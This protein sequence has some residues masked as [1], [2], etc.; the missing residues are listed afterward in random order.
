[1]S[2]RVDKCCLLG[3]ALMTE[4]K[5]EGRTGPCGQSDTQVAVIMPT[6]E[7]RQAALTSLTQREDRRRNS[8]FVIEIAL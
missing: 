3:G 6:P 2:T 7:L 8:T 5:S 4:K 1:M